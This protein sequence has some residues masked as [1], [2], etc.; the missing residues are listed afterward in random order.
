MV[1]A[2]CCSVE[3]CQQCGVE[4][5]EQSVGC[6]PCVVVASALGASAGSRLL[7]AFMQTEH[8]GR[9]QGSAGFLRIE[10]VYTG[11]H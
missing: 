10:L 4:Q 3:W 9:G 1:S 11:F 5:C 7:S 2:V 6:Q 8:Y